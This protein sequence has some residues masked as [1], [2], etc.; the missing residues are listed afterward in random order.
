[1][2]VLKEIFCNN[3]IILPVFSWFLAQLYKFLNCLVVNKRIDFMKFV[4][5]GGMP[6][7]HSAISVCLATI[8]GMQYGFESGIFAFSVVFALVVMADAA[9]V[10]RAA[11]KQ[12]ALLNKL[13]N[14]TKEFRAEKDLKELLG[15]TPVEVFAGAALGILVA[16]IFA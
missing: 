14:S 10:R 13:A 5:S 7:S 1:M 15:H 11:G 6:S 12:A 4:S 2:T 16:V 9:G 3:A 8:M